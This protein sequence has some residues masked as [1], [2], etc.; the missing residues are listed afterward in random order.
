MKGKAKAFLTLLNDEWTDSIAS[1][2]LQTLQE[3]KLTKKEQLP[4]TSDLKKLLAYAT[5]AMGT[6][7]RKLKD[8]PT[9]KTWHALS[10]TLYVMITIFN[11]RRGGE[12][13][14]VRVDSFDDRENDEHNE[15][16]YQSLSVFERQL[17]KR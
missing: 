10:A 7:V 14:K 15:D 12:V 1:P 4:S 2:A 5:T 6:E 17:V 11:K 13:A 9:P 16:V 8:C 3:R